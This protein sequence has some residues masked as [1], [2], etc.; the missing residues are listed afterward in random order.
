MKNFKIALLSDSHD[1][2]EN[3][4]K[5]I[6]F[7]NRNNCT[8]LF[9][10]GDMVSP[11][12][13][14]RLKNFKGEITVLYGNCDFDKVNLNKAV[15]LSGGNIFQPPHRTEINGRSFILMHEPVLIERSI[16]DG[17]ADYIFFGHTHDAYLKKE[18][19]TVIINPGECSGIKKNQ[20]FFILDIINDTINKIE[21]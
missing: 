8:H 1:H 16:K 15:N 4:K 9:H 19:N 10:L 11:S 5:I 17:D 18:N 12:T 14:T 6:S 7:A 21:L 13:A 3:L 20:T 2:V